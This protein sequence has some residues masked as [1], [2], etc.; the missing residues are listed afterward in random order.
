LALRG[1]VRVVERE[2]PDAIVCTH[3]LPVEALY[4]IRGQGPTRR[5]AA[6]VIT[7]YAAHPA[8]RTRTSIAT[9]WRRTGSQRS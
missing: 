5:A 8:W 7:D 1:L 2:R 9:S 3:F 4:P 6:V